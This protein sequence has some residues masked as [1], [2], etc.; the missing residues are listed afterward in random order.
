[1]N[2][3]TSI[4][5]VI[6]QQIQ[7]YIDMP[8]DIR[9][10]NIMNNI[11]NQ[12]NNVIV[13]IPENLPN[14]NALQILPNDDIDDTFKSAVE[15]LNNTINYNEFLNGIQEIRNQNNNEVES[16]NE[17]ANIDIIQRNRIHNEAE[18]RI[19]FMNRI[20]ERNKD[21]TNDLIT[22]P[23]NSRVDRSTYSNNEGGINME[24]MH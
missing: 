10:I 4:I 12:N 24:F 2:P 20:F 5:D 13:V 22:H 1:M 7:P 11:R 23:D 6:P 19:L 18:R 15:T 16:N 3:N 8:N 21:I 14:D 9:N 17:I